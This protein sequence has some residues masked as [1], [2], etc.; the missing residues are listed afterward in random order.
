M[1]ARKAKRGFAR[2]ARQALAG[3]LTLIAVVASHA[4]CG[5]ATRATRGDAGTTP[6]WSDA[7]E[8]L[9]A[10]D[11]TPSDDAASPDAAV[12]SSPSPAADRSFGDQGALNGTVVWLPLGVASASDGSLYVSGTTQDGT[13]PPLEIVEHLTAAGLLDLGFGDGGRITQPLGPT[14]FAQSLVVL[15]DGRVAVVGGTAL[16]G[17]EGGFVLRVGADGAP[18][19]GVGPGGVYS[20]SDVG[21]IVAGLFDADGSLLVLGNGGVARLSSSGAR[22]TTFASGGPLPGAVSGALARGGPWIASD[23]TAIREYSAAGAIDLSF[24]DAGAIP[25]ALAAP[26]GGAG[27]VSAVIVDGAGRTVAAGSHAEGLNTFL[28]VARY[29]AAGAVDPSFA[30]GGTASILAGVP[31]GLAERSGG[32][33]VMWTREGML[34][35][36][37]D[38]GT[39]DTTPGRGGIVDLGVLGTVLAGTVDA[40]ER[41]VVVGLTTGTDPPTWFVRR[42]VL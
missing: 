6:L 12:S 35:Y 29:T 34:V 36:V 37:H 13:Y 10:A 8:S 27:A 1:N 14:P 15:P 32:G 17:A 19:P 7:G 39:F 42:Y 11:A 2:S 40:R 30:S 26:D 16:G 33:I 31:L 18:D 4:A 41:L 9:D 21:L 22:D 25:Q 23:G 28:D 38:D 20:A 24:G 3:R 5:G